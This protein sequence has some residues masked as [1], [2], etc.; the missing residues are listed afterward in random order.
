MRNLP[1]VEQIVE[2]NKAFDSKIVLLVN[3]KVICLTNEKAIEDY[4]NRRVTDLDVSIVNN[5]DRKGKKI[6]IS[7]EVE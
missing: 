2:L 5:W 7:L 4:G 3:N 1:T 6:V